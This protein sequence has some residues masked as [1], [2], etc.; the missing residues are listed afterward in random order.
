AVGPAITAMDTRARAEAAELSAETDRGRTI[1]TR[2][3]QQPPAGGAGP[4]LLWLTRHDP[5]LLER[6]ATMLFCKDVLR[7]RL[8]GE[9]GT[10]LSDAT[11]TF[12]DTRTATWSPQI[13]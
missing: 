6:A 13:L 9:S 8:T 11:A 12:L 5:A 7:L 4:L 10:D 2:S 3:G 1:L